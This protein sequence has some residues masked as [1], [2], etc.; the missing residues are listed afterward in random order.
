MLYQSI[1]Y[2]FHKRTDSGILQ[3]HHKMIGLIIG[4]NKFHPLL[5]QIWP[6][7]TYQHRQTIHDIVTNDSKFS[8]LSLCNTNSNIRDLYYKRLKSSLLRKCPAFLRSDQSYTFSEEENKCDICDVIDNTEHL[9]MKCK[10]K[11]N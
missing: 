8:T 1:I 9:I 11:L 7:M 5:N 3:C 4:L 10:T 2:Q 6:N